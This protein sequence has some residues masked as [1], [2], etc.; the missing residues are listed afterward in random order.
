MHEAIA[1]RRGDQEEEE[2]EEGE[3]GAS[4][5][6]N[7]MAQL[8]KCSSLLIRNLGLQVRSIFVPSPRGFAS[9]L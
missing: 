5:E 6:R 1:G 7:I 3:G 8:E 4:Q 9:E 2:E